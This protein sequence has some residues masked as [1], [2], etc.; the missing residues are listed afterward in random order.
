MSPVAGHSDQFQFFY[1]MGSNA[2]KLLKRLKYNEILSKTTQLT[3]SNP[4]PTE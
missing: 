1:F 2:M 4:E 3:W